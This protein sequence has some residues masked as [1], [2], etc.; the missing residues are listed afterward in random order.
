MQIK[1]QTSQ[2]VFIHYELASLGARIGAYFIDLVIMI[3]YYILAL[4]VYF[5]LLQFNI[6]WPLVF[7]YL[8]VFFYHLVNELL[9]DGQSIGKKQL[10]I[11]VIKLN[12]NQPGIGSYLLRWILRPIDIISFGAVAILCII[13]GGKGQRLGD[14]AAGTS[15]IDTKRRPVKPNTKMLKESLE[16][17]YVPSFKQAINLSEKDIDII[18]EV[19][20]SYKKNG[21]SKPLHIMAEKTKEVLGVES[22]LN[23]KEFLQVIVKDYNHLA[24]N[25]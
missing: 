3:A 16:A 2:N 20:L 18:M 23:P 11:K 21:F 15:V 7:I 19:L 8:P 4:I 24:A 12:G 17:G 25:V 13:I 6:Y 22:D 14:M 10:N 1:V 9:L 5:N